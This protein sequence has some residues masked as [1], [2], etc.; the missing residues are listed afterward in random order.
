MLSP[1]SALRRA[2]HTGAHLPHVDV[3]ADLYQRGVEFRGSQLVMVTGRPGAGKTFLAQWLVSEMATKAKAAG[4]ECPGLYFFLDGTPFT[5]A[6]RQAA[7]ATGDTTQS[8]T[9]ALDGPGAAYYEDAL[10]ELGGDVQ[11]VFDRKPELPDIQAEL[12]AY[13]EMWDRYPSWMVFDNL[14]NVAG[15]EEVHH[16]QK[17]ALGEFQSL[18]FRTGACVL[19]LHHA[20]EAGVKDYSKPPRVGDTDGK[21]TQLPETVL[22]VAK[23]PYSDRFSIAVGKLRDGGAADPSAENPVVLWA[24]LARCSF[25]NQKPITAP[26]WGGWDGEDD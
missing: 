5:A 1:S 9:A 26:A 14:L 19:V 23:D 4:E 3:L 24:D 2:A 11:F 18:A 22:T 12:D 21:V 8:I 10:S 15:C 7:W 6:V 20:S 16:A 25:S 13:V 17:F